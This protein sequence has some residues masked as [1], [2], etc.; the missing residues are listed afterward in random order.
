MWQRLTDALWPSIL[1]FLAFAAGLFG[2]VGL[3][4]LREVALARWSKRLPY[5]TLPNVARVAAIAMLT[6]A[7]FFRL[8]HDYYT[9][10]HWAAFLA[11]LF[12]CHLAIKAN[13]SYWGALFLAGC[14]VFYPIQAPSLRRG[15]WIIVDAVA[16]LAL[17]LSFRF[18]GKAVGKDEKADAWMVS[19]VLIA[20]FAA[21]LFEARLHPGRV[22]TDYDDGY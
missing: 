20:T 4:T 22:G 6:A 10:L 17:L 18:A 7:V 21:F 16:A 14:I 2:L 13:Q 19:A 3:I 5:L 12:T 15:T 1:W 8:P 9:M 11:C